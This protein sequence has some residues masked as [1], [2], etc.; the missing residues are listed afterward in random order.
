MPNYATE[1]Q[2]LNDLRGADLTKDTRREILRIARSYLCKLAV[3]RRKRG[4]RGICTA[5]DARAFLKLNKYTSADLGSAAG[6]LF[7]SG[8][9]WVLV[10]AV[11]SIVPS[12]RGRVIGEWSYLGP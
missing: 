5:D 8:Q 2:A 4:G 6:A 3:N 9:P 7:A 10:G 12:N 11:M 1:T